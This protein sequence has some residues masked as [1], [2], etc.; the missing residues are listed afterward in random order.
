MSLQDAQEFAASRLECEPP[1]R[2][3]QA[4]WEYQ[5]LA[6]YLGQAQVRPHGNCGWFWARVWFEL[7]NLLFRLTPGAT[8]EIHVGS[9]LYDRNW[10]LKGFLITE[11]QV[12]TDRV[13][14]C[15][16]ILPDE[17]KRIRADLQHEHTGAYYLE[18]DV[19]LCTPQQIVR[20]TGLDAKVTHSITDFAARLINL[21]GAEWQ[22]AHPG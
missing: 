18:A 20:M 8:L 7:D 12:S 13:D 6:S 22:D 15:L 9:T 16:R 19:D 10:W 4:L 1:C 17:P 14:E 5:P 11:E 3:L 21:K 2:P